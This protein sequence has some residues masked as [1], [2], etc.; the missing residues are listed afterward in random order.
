[1]NTTW[2]PLKRL[3]VWPPDIVS[4]TPKRIQ[5]TAPISLITPLN[6]LKSPWVIGGQEPIPLRDVTP[7]KSLQHCL[8]VNRSNKNCWEKFACIAVP[9]LNTTLKVGEKCIIFSMWKCSRFIEHFSAAVGFT[10][11]CRDVEILWIAKKFLTKY[12]TNWALRWQLFFVNH[13]VTIKRDLI[14]QTEAWNFCI[15]PQKT[16]LFFVHFCQHYCQRKFT[17]LQC[18][19][20][21][22][23]KKMRKLIF[24]HFFDI[25]ATAAAQWWAKNMSGKLIVV[26]LCSLVN[27]TWIQIPINA[28][29]LFSQIWIQIVFTLLQKRVF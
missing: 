13:S 22:S 19:W 4:V 29:S 11:R 20:R 15:V 26:T 21:R 7:W 3:H 6:T 25:T 10:L 16:K 24:F 17:L 8:T 1:M 5:V 12:G 28:S 18:E 2:P 23:T 9:C 27:W 14:K